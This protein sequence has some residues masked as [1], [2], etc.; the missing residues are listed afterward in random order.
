M[1]QRVTDGW[2]D[3]GLVNC[4]RL[5]DSIQCTVKK[6]IYGGTQSRDHSSLCKK[7]NKC[8]QPDSWAITHIKMRP[9]TA[10]RLLHLWLTCQGQL[11][12]QNRNDKSERCRVRQSDLQL[13]LYVPKRTWSCQISLAVADRRR[14]KPRRSN[15][16]TTI[17]ASAVQYYIPLCSSTHSTNGRRWAAISA[18]EICS[19]GAIHCLLLCTDFVQAIAISNVNA[20]KKQ[21]KKFRVEWLS[22]MLTQNIRIAMSWR[23]R[24]WYENFVRLSACHAVTYQNGDI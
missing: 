2:T 6:M 22:F 8:Q 11:R 20:K 1:I 5:H 19:R 13:C 17:R 7:W 9:V 12:Q 24:H 3:N 15:S 4:W 23:A 14:T 21:E 10:T 18:D 16:S